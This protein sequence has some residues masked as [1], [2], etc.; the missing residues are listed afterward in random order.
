[1]YPCN[2]ML[3]THGIGLQCIPE[4]ATSCMEHDPT[5]HVGNL[6]CCTWH[7]V[8]VQGATHV[9]SSWVREEDM[10][11]WEHP[12]DIQMSTQRMEVG[13]HAA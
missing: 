3:Q 13:L 8:A 4:V 6:L 11:V 1:M 12:L 7:C 2:L 5:R 10:V 9:A